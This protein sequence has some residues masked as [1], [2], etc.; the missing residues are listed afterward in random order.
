MSADGPSAIPKSDGRQ[1]PLGI[2]ALEDEIVQRAVV[3][4]L[5]AVYEEDLLGSS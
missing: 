5:D 1:R 4:V 3:V 2:T